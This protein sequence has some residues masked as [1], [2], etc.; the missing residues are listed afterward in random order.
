M[1]QGNELLK[2]KQLVVNKVTK[3]VMEMS[4]VSTT[5]HTNSWGGHSRGT[6]KRKWFAHHMS[7][8][9]ALIPRD[10][11]TLFFD[12]FRLKKKGY[13]KNP[14]SQR[15][16]PP[17]FPMFPSSSHVPLLNDGIGSV[18]AEL[19]T[20]VLMPFTSFSTVSLSALG[21]HAGSRTTCRCFLSFQSVMVPQS[22]LVSVTLNF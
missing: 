8:R 17:I 3:I 15:H 6:H 7:E 12:N 16:R 4:S 13:R 19:P 18:A 10:L 14:E 2:A 21:S 1:C 11:G 22:F 5:F 20:P 9:W